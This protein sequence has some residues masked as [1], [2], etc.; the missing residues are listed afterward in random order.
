VQST[1][2]LPFAGK[3]LL[4]RRSGNGH[5]HTIYNPNWNKRTF[6]GL[7][8]NENNATDAVNSLLNREPFP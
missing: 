7:F 5:A 1:K 8:G 6:M 2:Q 4:R 3:F